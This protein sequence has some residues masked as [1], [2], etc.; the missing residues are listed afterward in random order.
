MTPRKIRSVGRMSLADFD[1]FCRL[2]VLVMARG[3][4][5]DVGAAQ[6][7]RKTSYAGEAGGDVVTTA[8][9]GAQRRLMELA[10]RYLPEQVG[11]IGEENGLRRPS[12]LTGPSVVLT[13]DPADGTRSLI[14]AIE[15]HRQPVPGEVSAMLGVQVDGVAVGAYICDVGDLMTYMRTPYDSRVLRVTPEGTET[16]MSTLPRAQ[17]LAKGTLL[18]HGRRPIGTSLGNRLVSTAFG[19]IQP[20][21]NSI[22][23]TVMGVFSGQFVAALRVAGTYATPWDDTPVQAACYRSHVVTL[24]VNRDR[25]EELRFDR[26]DQLT[27]CDYDILYVARQ[28]LPELRRHAQ[29][30]T[31]P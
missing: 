9:L 8:D 23:L 7:Q 15:A 6:V 19:R 16:D 25:L 30:I 18:R 31:F 4:R 21:G 17:S 1:R 3:I 12:T 13:I 29:V 26:L 5:E 14:K 11:L 20:G 28:Y 2:S 22:G 27:R 10:G 24:R